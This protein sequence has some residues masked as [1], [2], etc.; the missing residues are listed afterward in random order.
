M[1]GTTVVIRPAFL[2]VLA[3]A[4]VLATALLTANNTTSTGTLTI[5]SPVDALVTALLL[6][7]SVVLHEI[8]HA[9]ACSA[10]RTRCYVLH[11]GLRSSVSHA[12]PQGLQRAAIAS[13]GPLTEIAAGGMLWIAS[14][15]SW[16]V[17]LSPITTAALCMIISG[18]LQLLPISEASD[19]WRVRTALNPHQTPPETAPK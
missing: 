11:L 13:A 16:H 15:S 7:G 8:G 14:G 10:V 5:A 12:A 9:L 17:P 1:R 3:G 6:A 2:L 18:A 4:W 19:G